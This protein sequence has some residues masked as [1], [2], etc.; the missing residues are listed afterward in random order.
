MAWSRDR[1]GGMSEGSVKTVVN[2]SRMA[3]RKSMARQDWT[4]VPAVDAVP[5]QR[6]WRPPSRTTW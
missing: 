2:S 3:Q 4:V 6:N 1:A 5:L